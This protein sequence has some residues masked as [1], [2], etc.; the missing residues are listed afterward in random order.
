MLAVLVLNVSMPPFANWHETLTTAEA[1][2]MS[3]VLQVLERKI[4]LLVAL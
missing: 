3:L 1:D 4:Y 2:E